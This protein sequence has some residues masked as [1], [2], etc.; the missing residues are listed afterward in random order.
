M[1]P[2]AKPPLAHEPEVR[3]NPR[4][5]RTTSANKFRDIAATGAKTSYFVITDSPQ[6][7]YGENPNL[8]PR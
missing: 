8:F 4:M 1:N 7:L 5:R 2:T 3:G 6:L